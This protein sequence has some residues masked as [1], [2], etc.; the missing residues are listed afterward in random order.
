MVAVSGVAS[1][2]FVVMAN[3]WMNAPTGFDLVGGKAINVDPIAGM[4]NPM[5]FQQTLH[6]TLA[7]YAATGLA[8]AGI[9]A[10][11]LLIDRG[12]PSTGGRWPSRCW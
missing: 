4:L 10:F 2:I 5:M 3:A 11:L 9:H 12:T 8:V 7:A 1:G 6:M